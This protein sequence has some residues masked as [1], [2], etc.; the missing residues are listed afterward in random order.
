[1]SHHSYFSLVRVLNPKIF[2]M[3]PIEFCLNVISITKDS[4]LSPMIL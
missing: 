1:M 4:Y 2:I 3:P